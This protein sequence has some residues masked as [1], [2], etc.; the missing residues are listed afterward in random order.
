MPGQMLTFSLATLYAFIV[1]S[2]VLMRCLGNAL[3]YKM[4]IS[5]LRSLA[6]V[7]DTGRSQVLIPVFLAS[8]A[9]KHI[10]CGCPKQR[11]RR[12]RNY[13]SVAPDQPLPEN[14][15]L[16]DQAEPDYTSILTSSPHRRNPK[17]WADLLEQYLPH[18]LRLDANTLTTRILDDDG[19]RSIRRLPRLLFNARTT[20]PLKLDLLSYVGVVQGRWEAVLWLVK[21]M[22]DQ[23]V[24]SNTPLDWDAVSSMHDTPWSTHGESLKDLTSHPIW[25]E[26]ST[27][28]PDPGATLSEATDSNPPEQWGLIEYM[29]RN[30]IGQI[31][32]SIG[33]MVLQAADLPKQDEPFKLIMFN[34]YQILAHLHHINALPETIYNY[35][36]AQDP[37]VLQKPPTLN[38]LSSHIMTILSDT[39]WK[40]HEKE[41]SLNPFPL[42]ANQAS[43]GYDSPAASLQPRIRE[44]GP[45]VWLDLVLWSCVEGGWITEGA[46]LVGEMMRRKGEQRWSAVNWHALSKPSVKSDAWSRVK[47]EIARS[48]M[49]QIARG[50]SIAGRLGD[51]AILET[52][53]RTVSSEVIVALVD[54]LVNTTRRT[55][56]VYGNS[57][58]DVQRYLNACKN[59]LERKHFALDTNAWNGIILRLVE[60]GGF[61][62][63]A[64][65][66]V[67]EY[68]INL[69]PSYLKESEAS[70]V[71]ESPSSSARA[72]AA[73]QTTANLGL[74]YR[75]LHAFSEQGDLQGALRTFKKL[76]A[77][78]DANRN[79]AIQEL[80]LNLGDHKLVEASTDSPM[81]DL[82]PVPGVHPS[83]PTNVLA[84]FLDL[85]TEAKAFDF[86]KWLLYSDEVDGPTI[87]PERYS[88]E[89][90]QPALLRFAT[91]T[92]DAS[93][94]NKITKTL[95]APL[96]ENILRALMR[97]QIALRKWDAVGDLLVYFQ[98][99]EG[100]KWNA[101]DVMILARAVLRLENDTKTSSFD[102]AQLISKA[103]ALLQGLLQGKYDSARDPSQLPDPSQ[104]Q[105]AN[106]LRRIL[107]TVP[108]SLSEVAAT[109]CRSYRVSSS[110]GVS[111]HAFNQLLE[112]VVENYGSTAGRLLWNRWC[113]KTDAD[114]DR[115]L[116]Q[117]TSEAEQVVV[118]NL[119]LLRTIMR[120]IALARYSAGSTESSSGKGSPSTGEEQKQ[121]NHTPTAGGRNTSEQI[122]SGNDGGSGQFGSEEEHDLLRWGSSMYRNFGLTDKEIQME[123]PGAPIQGESEE[124]SWCVS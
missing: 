3:N 38:L 101:V 21:A 105:M 77:L 35:A 58:T 119:Q 61:F 50:I 99:E 124:D 31:W 11:T 81:D 100:M 19:L 80:A 59:L 66:R 65:P 118:P 95:E 49:N 28:H 73:D 56:N 78:V 86:G 40:V 42:T 122:G 9:T 85:V 18:K 70:K 55:T 69:T 110:C 117:R 94:L 2:N 98:E 97:C 109:V 39:A 88:D 8:T 57:P 64:E 15:I 14:D 36:S 84:T 90:I 96:P 54:G 83:I 123:L 76:Q 20:Q 121:A 1:Y 24:S 72:Y 32:Q 46:W 63:E 23:C 12:I 120:P 107:Q 17:A 4:K 13:A 71:D 5:T 116:L 92:A 48:R 75:N 62:P 89:N 115:R 93:L 102:K 79:R 29:K 6:P 47:S 114:A 87:P 43:S 104:I 106:Q 111:S 113:R 108:G 45:E 22:L 37:S 41:G 67:L 103:H 60:S 68:I 25:A 74:L 44:L 51:P 27:L 7:L 53:P 10:T 33:C 34:V 91:A 16:P 30:G 82:D 112:G 26:K 52:V